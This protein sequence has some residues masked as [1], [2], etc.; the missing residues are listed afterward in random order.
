MEDNVTAYLEFPNGAT[1]VFITS[2]GE[3]PGTNRF[4]IAGT[5]G[6]LVLEKDKI[7]FTRN[8]VSMT[9]HCRTSKIGFIKPDVWHCDIPFADSPAQHAT[10]LQNFVNAILDGEE[11]ICR[12]DE[13]L[14]SIELANAILYSSLIDATLTLPLDGAA[15]ESHLQKLIQNSTYIKS[16]EAVSNEDFARSFNK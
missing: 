11:L 8:E 4:E 7:S 15:Y 14:H 16:V 3:A 9:D 5:L 13:G 12:G 10:L 1:G 2:S 6:K